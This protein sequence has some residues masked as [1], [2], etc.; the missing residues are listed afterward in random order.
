MP[1]EFLNRYP[2]SF[3]FQY[4]TKHI[5][6]KLSIHVFIKSSYHFSARTYQQLFQKMLPVWF[7]FSRLNL[8]AIIQVLGL[9]GNHTLG[10]NRNTYTLQK[11]MDTFLSVF[12]RHPFVGEWY[13]DT[14]VSQMCKTESRL[15]YMCLNANTHK[16]K[17]RKTLEN[18]K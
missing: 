9:K 16:W 13:A 6:E 1:S 4:I 14:R 12:I 10:K 17:E 18:L 15:Q 8:H 7:L 3:K 2:H 5:L 11:S